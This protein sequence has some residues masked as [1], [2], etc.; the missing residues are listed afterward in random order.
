MIYSIPLADIKVSHERMREDLGDI[1]SLVASLKSFGQLQPI[2]VTDNNELVDGFRRYTALSRAGITTA[3]VIQR[4]QMSELQ[5]REVELEANIQRK[6]M[7]WQERVKAIAEIDDLRRR[8][9]PNWSQPKTA[10]V[11]GTHQ[12][13]VSQA[14]QLNKM[15]EL[16]PEIKE[17]KSLNQA[18][19]WAKHKAATAIRVQEISQAPEVFAAIED[20]I[21][22]GDSVEVIKTLP[23]DFF[24][25]II[26]DPPFGIG[27][28]SR[29]TNKAGVETAYDDS[30]EAYERLLTM[31]PDLYRVLKPNGWFVWFFGMSW[32][33][34]CVDTF[35][36]AGFKVDPLPIIW[37]RSEGRC[38]TNRP[39]KYMARAYDVAL[40]CH[41][42]DPEMV[43][44]GKPN[45]IS[46]PP[47]ETHDRE[48]MVERPVELYEEIIR[49]LTIPGELVADFFVGSGS[50]M[51]AAA[52]TGRAYW[53]CELNPERRAVALKKIQGYTPSGS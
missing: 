49:R 42:G 39:D 48:L 53:G 35:E 40:H 11:M 38:H 17:A 10:A 6:D 16:F 27:Y 21:V 37:N 3:L 26:T 50:C 19:S 2:I 45:V 14:L 12:A 5:L 32:Y 33:Q 9:D 31:A 36:A 13:V 18:R 43:V 29:K 8:Q 15:L 34:R 22:L 44:R 46:I 52:S 25:A 24:H 28:D 51:A 1:E 20:R 4:D 47:V 23:D 41:K 30:T 7:T